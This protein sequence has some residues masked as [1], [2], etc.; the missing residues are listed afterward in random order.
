MVAF[1]ILFATL[2]IIVSLN[3]RRQREEEITETL[4]AAIETTVQ[5]LLKESTYEVEDDEEFIADF[6]EA[7]LVQLGSET[8]IEVNVLH[9][10][11]EKGLLSIEV[12][13]AY[14]HP[15]GKKGYISC[16]RTILFDTKE[17]MT[18]EVYTVTYYYSRLG[19]ADKDIYKEYRILAG[20]ELPV[21]KEPL[22][23]SGNGTFVTWKNR[24]DDT[25]PQ[26]NQKVTSDMAFYAV[27]T[28]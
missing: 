12:K 16:C 24:A 22:P 4:S 21:P 2:A 6:L 27:F 20:E 18:T 26:M 7:L 14:E 8:D 15:N 3:G 13:A 1:A 5:N 28:E 11:A 19:A 23:L 17:V 9:A 25:E 10:D